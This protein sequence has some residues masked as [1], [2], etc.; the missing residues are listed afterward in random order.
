MN[1]DGTGVALIVPIL[2]TLKLRSLRKCSGLSL[3]QERETFSL[4]SLY[5]VLFAYCLEVV[6]EINKH[7]RFSTDACT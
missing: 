1:E 4:Y 5:S 3:L 6:L 2:N 7:V